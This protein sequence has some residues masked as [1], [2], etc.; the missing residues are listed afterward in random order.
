MIKYQAQ[1]TAIGPLVSEFVDAGVLVFFGQGAPD[2]LAEFAILHDGTHLDGA[3]CPGDHINLGGQSFHVLAVGEVAN[4]NLS[5]LGHIII[6]FNGQTVPEM[7]GDVC[8]EA[9]PLPKIEVGMRFQIEA[10]E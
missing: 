4:R 1:I 6:K 9:I 8:T 7:P 5:A 10:P 3:I 2:E